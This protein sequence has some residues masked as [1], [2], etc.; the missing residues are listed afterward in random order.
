MEEQIESDLARATNVVNEI[1]EN[2]SMMDE[3][4]TVVQTENHHKESNIT[5]LIRDDAHTAEMML[6][7]A[8]TG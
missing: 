5:P 7:M 2:P 6:E 3:T 4:T 1:A 8:R